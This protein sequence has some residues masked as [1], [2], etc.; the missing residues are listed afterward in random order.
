M[1]WQAT[2]WVIEHSKHKGSALLTLLCIANCSNE[3]GTDAFP[4]IPRLARDT[5]MSLRQVA[6]IIDKLEESGELKVARKEGRSHHY[7]FPL[8]TP[9]KMSGVKKRQT[10]DI[11]APTPD[12]LTAT[13]DIAMSPDPSVR[14]VSKNSHTPR[15]RAKGYKQELKP[16]EEKTQLPPPDFEVTPDLKLWLAE[17]QIAFPPPRIDEITVQWRMACE[18]EGVGRFR[19]LTN[20]QAKWKKYVYW[21]WTNR[22][23]HSNGNGNGHKKFEQQYTGPVKSKPNPKLENCPDCNGMGN[24]RFQVDGIWYAKP[25]NHERSEV[26]V[27]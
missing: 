8:M 27:A 4:G 2:A 5:R 6:R 21:T 3:S 17:M 19:N 10:P 23:G 11:P 24:V 16:P 12:I 26:A 1:S 13:P 14:S 25:C 20:W 18:A 9:D 15:E 22:N 7:S